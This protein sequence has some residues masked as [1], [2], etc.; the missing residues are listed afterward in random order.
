MVVILVGIAIEVIGAIECCG[1]GGGYG[2]IAADCLGAYYGGSAYAGVAGD[3]GGT[4]YLEIIA[5]GCFG[6]D[7]N[8]ADLVDVFIVPGGE[9]LVELFVPWFGGMGR[10]LPGG[11][12]GSIGGEDFA[13]SL[14]AIVNIEF[15]GAVSVEGE[16]VCTEGD[17][18]SF[19]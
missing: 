5:I 3:V 6:A 14:T 8:F 19:V 1:A 11:F 9:G 16:V 15:S 7:G 13:Q 18:C 12:T 2:E 4:G 17:G 10:G